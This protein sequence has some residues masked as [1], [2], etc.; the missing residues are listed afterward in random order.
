MRRSLNS[1]D[2]DHATHAFGRNRPRRWGD[3]DS[4]AHAL[5][6]S[7]TGIE[8]HKALGAKRSVRPELC[9]DGLS[10]VTRLNRH[11][12][13]LELLVAMVVSVVTVLV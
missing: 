10:S 11:F 1:A 9:F 4:T 12:K 2:D 8:F 5:H 7:W 13:G 3:L 6:E